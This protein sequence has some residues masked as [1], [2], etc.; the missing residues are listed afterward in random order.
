MVVTC[1]TCHYY[2]LSSFTTSMYSALTTPYD[3]RSLLA[4][5][6]G[7]AAPITAAT[8]PVTSQPALCAPYPIYAIT[9]SSCLSSYLWPA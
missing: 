6:T 9:T 5:T 2:D 1:H 3:L 4:C 8:I 7:Y